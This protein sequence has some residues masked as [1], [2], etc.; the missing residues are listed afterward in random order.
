MMR[1]DGVTFEAV[2]VTCCAILSGYKCQTTGRRSPQCSNQGD[3]VKGLCAC[4]SGYSGYDCSQLDPSIELSCIDP[5]QSVEKVCS[6][7]GRCVGGVCQCARRRSRIP[8]KFSGEYCECDDYS[9]PFYMG[10]MCGGDARGRCNC[11]VCQCG[12][13]YTGEA[14]GCSLMT[15]GCVASDGSLCNNQGSCVCGYCQCDQDSIYRGPT[16]EEN[17]AMNG[18]RDLKQC[19][20][21]RVFQTG[22]LSPSEC[23]NDHVCSN[24]RI[25]SVDTLNKHE[26]DYICQFTDEKDDCLFRFGYS[27]EQTGAK[28]VKA[29]TVKQCPGPGNND[30]DMT[31]DPEVNPVQSDAPTGFQGSGD[32]DNNGASV[33]SVSLLTTFGTILVVL[34]RLS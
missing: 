3:L 11:G 20:Q 25:H 8:D 27:Y 7:R 4:I 15:D 19:V 22:P 23:A 18:C 13:G 34:F 24:L 6:G 14:C 1:L 21:C 5:F 10:R 16:C 32:P 17:P 12:P 29:S 31:L 30:L 26:S 9:C 28:F 2:F 33:P